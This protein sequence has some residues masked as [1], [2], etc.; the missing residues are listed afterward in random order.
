M[1]VVLSRAPAEKPIMGIDGG[2]LPAKDVEREEPPGRPG[3]VTDD[4]GGVPRG[5][6]GVRVRRCRAGR[7]AAS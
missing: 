7:S 3:A 5:P 4:R 6:R 2:Y 1:P